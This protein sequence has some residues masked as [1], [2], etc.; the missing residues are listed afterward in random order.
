MQSQN[1]VLKLQKDD[2][3]EGFLLVRNA[4]N[5]VGS[6]GSP[7]LD[8][9]L[10]DNSGDINAKVWNTAETAPEGGSVIK[11]RAGVT[12]FNGRLQLRV[13]KFRLATEEDEVDLSL[14]VP[15]APEKPEVMLK[16]VYDTIE[17]MQNDVLKKIV[18][19]I[20]KQYE[21]KLI[22]YPA[23]QSLHHAER[24]G[25]LNHTTSMLNVAKAIVTCYPFLDEDLLYSGIILH[26]IGKILELNSDNFGNVSDYTKDGLLLGH[27][28][29][30]VSLIRDT[31]RQLNIPEDD[32]YTLLLEHMVLSHHGIAEYGSTRPPM[33]PEAEML[34]LIDVMDARMNE[35]QGVL[36][37][38]PRGVFS[39]RIWSLD[40]RIYHP[41][42]TEK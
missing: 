17:A 35:M 8:M 16:Q 30:G 7:Y 36:E 1:K 18:H 25:L 12:E 14:L 4:S 11:L 42:Y 22:Y 31:A 27:L 9:M 19:S 6:T 28:V 10:A 20:I 32:E 34:H 2:R 38:T 37:R 15:C 39:E 5:R 3:F 26:D 21:D 13:E 24:S 23:A 41:N 33:F 29:R 40:R